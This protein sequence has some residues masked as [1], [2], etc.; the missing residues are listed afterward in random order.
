MST[1]AGRRVAVITVSDYNLQYLRERFGTEAARVQRV[2]N[3]L[4]LERFAYQSPADRPPQ[5]V[6]VGRL[7]EKKGFAG[8]VEACHILAQRG[9]QY[10]CQIIGSGEQGAELRARVQRLGLEGK[11]EFLGPRPQGEVVRHIQGAAVFAAPCVVGQ[12]GNRDGLPTV[13][14][15]AMALGTPCVSTDVTGIP[16]IVQDMETGLMVPQHDPA[17]LATAIE[18]LLTDSALRV[19][20]ASRARRMIETEFDI[21]RNAARLRGVFQQAVHEGR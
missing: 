18:R 1:L 15:E 7:I 4:D 5:V 9:R 19:R 11:V 16:E 21:H 2:Y 6:A 3:G 20:L 14:L 8:L 10:S 17:A 12:D 13:L